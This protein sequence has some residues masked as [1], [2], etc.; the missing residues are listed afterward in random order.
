MIIKD[1]KKISQG[2]FG[3]IE[4]VLLV[5]ML[6][7]MTYFLLSQQQARNKDKN[8]SDF[9]H[10]MNNVIALVNQVLSDPH[11]CTATALSQATKSVGTPGAPA[12][13]LP[14]GRRLKGAAI[15]GELDAIVLGTA[16][17]TW[18]LAPFSD[19]SSATGVIV[20][21]ANQ[22][23]Y[24]GFEIGNINLLNDQVNDFI[25]IQFKYTA[26]KKDSIKATRILNRDFILSTK[27]ELN[28]IVECRLQTPEDILFQGCSKIGAW[29]S[30]LHFCN[31]P[32]YYIKSRDLF[33]LYED[34]NGG[35][36]QISPIPVPTVSR[37]ICPTAQCLINNYNCCTPA[38]CVGS[39]VAITM[40]S[41]LTQDP[42]TQS[43]V[44]GVCNFTSQC[45]A[46][47]DAGIL[48]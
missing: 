26:R 27:K 37:C 41:F 22:E 28:S 34:G 35:L 39:Y 33:P 14:V 32:N 7:A 47:P 36:T 25:R 44:G 4:V 5:A 10:E 17:I 24:P 13:M 18:P 16:N 29:D 8:K 40:K 2:G 45:L 19:M 6:S 30:L 31:I 1:K 15:G 9:N 23:I 48:K 11:N 43:I 3:I 20:F 46:R 42:P 38:T 21:S 12:P